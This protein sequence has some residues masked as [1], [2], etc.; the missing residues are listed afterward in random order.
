MT[1]AANGRRAPSWR[2]ALAF[3]VL[4]GVLAF[5]I[6][7]DALAPR[8]GLASPQVS[9]SVVESGDFRRQFVA[10]AK[11]VR[12]AVVAIA[13]VSTIEVPSTPFGDWPFEHFLPRLPG[14]EDDGARAPEGSKRKQKRRGMGSG[15]IVDAAK[16]LILTNNH[17][18][19]Q[20]DELTVVLDDDTELAAEIV[21]TDPKSD[22]AVIR[23]RDMKAA[24]HPLKAAI[25]GDSD[26]LEV[27][28]WVMAIGSPFGLKHTVS[29]GIVSAVGRGSMGIAEYEDFIQTDAAINPGNSGG[30]LVALDG[31]VIG[32]NTAIA[33]RSG[34]NMG[35]GFAIPIDMARTVMSQLLEHGSV[36]RGYLGIFI[37][38]L[39]TDLAKSF[40]HEG[41]GVLVQDVGKDGPA[42]S[43]GVLPGD[44]IIERDGKPVDDVAVFRNA[45]ARTPP[46]T[47]V[48]LTVIRDGKRKQLS[49][50]LGELPG[51]QAQRPGPAESA[52]PEPARFGLSL[53]DITPQM[54]ERFELQDVHGALV[55]AVAPDSAAAQAGLRPGDVIEQVQTTKI[56]SANDAL[57]ALRAAPTTGPLRL[58]IVREGR[59]Q[60]VLLPPGSE[61]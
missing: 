34:G 4:V 44:I 29:A 45:I 18:V 42:A 21:G 35:I 27:G 56:G 25:T 8:P 41:D 32:I 9:A 54:K 15:V 48:A 55:I 49:V 30:P 10:V 6:R 12:P 43:A 51:D 5:C 24:K 3:G 39:S 50:V 19:A 7:P 2:L 28:E 33:S 38:D 17:V 31:R 1:S 52:K 22:L 58:R 14:S 26:K 57:R 11:A 59:G 36:V 60:F 16:G 46:G 47:R 23:I 40:G 37:A 53:S 61:G 13:A 20:A